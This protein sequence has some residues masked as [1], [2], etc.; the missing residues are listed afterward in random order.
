MLAISNDPLTKQEL[1]ER[2]QEILD[3]YSDLYAGQMELDSYGNIVMSPPPSEWHQTQAEWISQCLKLILPSWTVVQNIGVLTGNVV[4]QPDVLAASWK[5]PKTEGKKPFDPAPEICVE[6][7]SPSNSRSQM[8][9]KQKLYLEAGAKEVWIC[10]EE[11]R[12]SFFTIQ[13]QIERSMVAPE[14]PLTI[15]LA[16]LPI[17]KVQREQIRL[18]QENAKL[19]REQIRLQQENAKL[20]AHEKVILQSYNRLVTSH[21]DRLKLQEEDPELVAAY[22]AII[23]AQNRNV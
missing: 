2:W 1:V 13:G 10:D 8:E 15:N 22:D 18:Q 20:Q 4:Q 9:R 5:R 12:M 7:L 3:L 6:V 21:E 11:N 19:Q 16:V 23:A 14:F 17:L